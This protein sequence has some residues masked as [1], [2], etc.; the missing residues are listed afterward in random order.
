MR[1]DKNDG[2]P[3]LGHTVLPLGAEGRSP[4]AMQRNDLVSIFRPER[5][6]GH[7]MYVV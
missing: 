6:T 3:S 7:P 4:Y 5:H 2:E 1:D